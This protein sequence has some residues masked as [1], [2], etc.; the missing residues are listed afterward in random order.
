M[1]RDSIWRALIREP[2]TWFAL[3]AAVLVAFD[4]GADEERRVV[5]TAAEIDGLLVDWQARTGRAPTPEERRALVDDYAAEGLWA[6]YARELGLERGDRIVRAWLRR[7]AEALAEAE[8]AP[9]TEEDLR[10]AYA[11]TEV[12][13]GGAAGADVRETS[14]GRRYTFTQTLSDGTPSSL[15]PGLT[16]ATPTEIAAV[17]GRGFAERLTALPPA[18][19]TA[20]VGSPFGRHRVRLT[21]VTTAPAPAFEQVRERLATELAQERRRAAVAERLAELRARY[22]LLV[23]EEDGHH[24]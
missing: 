24:E 2:L 4:G 15:P 17:F 11:K 21:S 9:V 23:E 14:A 6:R 12:R 16:A 10:A 3:V 18:P 8:A 1:S 22:G 13:G 5:V 19:T 7:K 20:E